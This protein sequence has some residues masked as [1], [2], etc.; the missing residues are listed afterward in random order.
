M[1]ANLAVKMAVRTFS[2]EDPDYEVVSEG[3]WAGYSWSAGK[4]FV[5]KRKS[6][7]KVW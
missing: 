3:S 6:D 2:G 7:R 5:M 1:L 4:M